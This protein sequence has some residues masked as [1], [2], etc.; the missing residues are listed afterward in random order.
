MYRLGR[1]PTRRVGTGIKRNATF[2]RAGSVVRRY[3]NSSS[4]YSTARWLCVCAWES[5]R[6]RKKRENN[7]RAAAADYDQQRGLRSRYT[8]KYVRRSPAASV[9]WESRPSS[10]RCC[11][12][13]FCV[14]SVVCALYVHVRERFPSSRPY[15]YRTQCATETTRVV[16]YYSTTRFCVPTVQWNEWRII[17]R[18]RHCNNAPGNLNNIISFV[19]QTYFT[20]RPR[21]QTRRFPVFFIGNL[22]C[23]FEYNIILQ[24]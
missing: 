10:F 9:S 2:D 7:E 6:A 14:R 19:V 18:V 23:F 5:E 16:V 1:G 11:A 13:L 20:R 15:V 8:V 4:S 24:I 22:T 12:S 3:N 17:R 21:I